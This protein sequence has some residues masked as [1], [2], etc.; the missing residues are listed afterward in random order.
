MV[1]EGRSTTIVANRFRA[2]PDHPGLT[3]QFRIPFDPEVA[4]A[5]RQG[6][7]PLEVCPDSPT[8]A[9]LREMADHFANQS[10]AAA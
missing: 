6:L 4:L 7:C 8:I 2:E 5:E 3:P 1:G 10:I 9:A